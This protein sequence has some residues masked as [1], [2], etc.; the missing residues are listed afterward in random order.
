MSK[1]RYIFQ[2]SPREQAPAGATA[3]AAA[4][5][6]PIRDHEHVS[7]AGLI[8]S[9]HLHPHHTQRQKMVAASCT[10]TVTRWLMPLLS[11][12]QA[13]TLTSHTPPPTQLAFSPGLSPSLVCLRWQKCCAGVSLA[14]LCSKTSQVPGC[15]DTSRGEVT[16]DTG[17]SVQAPA[18]GVKA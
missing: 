13:C 6:T 14:S 7:T 10:G 11:S 3:R 8:C 17:T 12:L 18:V 16:W 4:A 9:A 15:A 5:P 1:A 2:E